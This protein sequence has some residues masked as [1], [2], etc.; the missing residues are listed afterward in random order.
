MEFD[1]NGNPVAAN[2]YG[3]TGMESRQQFEN[4]YAA[5]FATPIPATDL[6]ATHLYCQQA[7]KNGATCGVCFL[8]MLWSFPALAAVVRPARR[9]LHGRAGLIVWLRLV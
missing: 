5:G 8:A 4:Q 3:P 6:P 2:I 9:A 1:N 7:F